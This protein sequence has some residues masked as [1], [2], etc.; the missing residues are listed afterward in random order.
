MRDRS[1]FIRL[2]AIASGLKQGFKEASAA[3][4]QTATDIEQAGRRAE[5]A[6]QK[7]AV[8]GSV[9]ARAGAAI[10]AQ[11]GRARGHVS[12]LGK[13][14]S[15][16][17]DEVDRLATS[18]T[19]MGGLV[20]A[21]AVLGAKR[22]A[23]F[24][25]AM[26]NVA[27]TGDDAKAS[28]GA[29][30]AEAIQ[31]GADTVFS[32]QEAAQGIENLEKA[33]VSAKDILGGGLSGTLNLAAAGQLGVADAAEI[34]ATAL[35]QFGLSG[36]Q[37]SHVADLLAAGAGKAQ[38]EVSDLALAL[39][40]VG[41]VA[42]GM[43]ISIEETTG[44]LAAFA[45]QGLI[46]D[47]AGTSLRGV[48]A[49]LTSPSAAA[50]QEIK[51]LGI[52]LYDSQGRFK[53]LA[54]VAGQLSSAY[55]G[56]S[57]KSRDA[58]LGI[59]FG[60]QQVTAARVLFAQGAEGVASWTE[61]VDDAGY[62]AR[63]A[64]TKMDNLKGDIE[65][66]SGSIDTVLIQSGS[67]LNDVLRGVTRTATGTVNAIGS[68]PAPVLEAG[69]RMTALAGAGLLVSGMLGK[70]VTSWVAYRDA[71]NKLGEDA[72]KTAAALNRAGSAATKVGLALAAIQIASVF[73]SAQQ[74]A[75]DK[76]HASLADVA[77]VLSG[78]GHGSDLSRLD[79]QF[80]QI[81]G[82][83]RGVGGALSA[84]GTIQGANVSSDIPAL[85]RN[86][87]SA[88]YSADTFVKS[89]F[90]TKSEMVQLQEQLGKV[91]QALAGM[92]PAQAQQAF[93]DITRAATEQGVSVDYLVGQF[94][95]YKAALQATA[96][97]LGVTT[98][99]TQDYAG[100]MAGKVPAA[101]SAA[102]S[103]GTGL[104]TN[105]TATQ[106]QLAGAG[107]SASDYA[108]SM[109]TVANAALKLSGS[110]IGFEQAVDDTAK[111]IEKNGKG[112]DTNTAKGRANQRALDQLYASGTAYVQ[113]L[114]AQGA[115]GDEAASVMERVRRKYI[116]SA[117]AAGASK[118]EAK[119][120]ADALGLIPRDVK[121]D[122]DTNLNQDGIDDWR[123]YKPPG[124]DAWITP[125]LTSKTLNANVVYHVKGGP[126]FTAADGGILALAGAD[127]V[128]SF[129]AGGFDGTIGAAQPQIQPNHGPRGIL[130]AET[131]SGP[132]EGFV[133]GNPAKADRSR[134]ITSEIARRLGGYAQFADGG[135]RGIPVAQRAAASTP[136]PAIDYARL[137][138]AIASAA[139]D[140]G[141]SLGFLVDK[142]TAE[143]ARSYRRS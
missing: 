102:I 118:T 83:V 45:S 125:R 55:A 93:A 1:V 130:W 66:L 14:I 141:V 109:F 88:A 95:G 56:M 57:D 80:T 44:A 47:Q 33:G 115:T 103:S 94:P 34:A 53:G 29:L 38:G 85:G 61:K 54:N 13:E 138:A 108:D 136:T 121:T 134:A 32:A 82:G 15:A 123:R 142:V 126:G 70:G 2:G 65:Q 86:L 21:G 10:G 11:F 120:M 7:Q 69:A 75:I 100:W 35:T 116:E 110:Q 105:L 58:S 48:L 64:A 51:R 49:S 8:A 81:S 140:Q 131:G 107:Q 19:V 24:D 91:D 74:A 18:A 135:T 139:R 133:S 78:M 117:I 3:A 106:Q 22:F 39:K 62:A 17:R 76:T 114:V 12:A 30:R 96:I 71:V 113:N 137:G 26:S 27:A 25:A 101:I 87:L 132:W 60:N 143:Q 36:S 92:D 6:T 84:L 97:Q 68:I 99:S 79:A 89:M 43:G 129:A 9:L 37:M 67:G 72:P 31:L 41:P 46:G 73:G 122:I 42:A 111:A 77:E 50:S 90:G 20:A 5:S 63:A 119:G 59:L 40:Y 98:L 23:D 4:R 52:S 124:K 28:L 112:L 104:N 128:R 127:I 16:N